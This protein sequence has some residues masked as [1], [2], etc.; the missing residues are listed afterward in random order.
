MS[1]PL[2]SLPG[3]LTVAMIATATSPAT[4]APK[5]AQAATAAEVATRGQ[6]EAKDITYGDWQKLCFKAGGAPTLCRTS[7]TGKFPTG[8]TAV[9]V[10]LIEREDAPTARLQL[11]VPAGMY[12]QQPPKLSIDGRPPIRVPYTWCLSNLCIAANVAPPQVV[13]EME[14]GKALTLELVDANLLAVTT[15][16]PL[17]QFAAAHK[18]APAKTLEQYVEE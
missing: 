10:D 12:L 17:T 7:V 4:A 5:A 16:I 13:K 11:F 9:R 1:R 18:G 3:L 2:H 6:R 14:A 8:Q 15:A